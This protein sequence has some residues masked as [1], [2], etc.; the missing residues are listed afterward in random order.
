MK[1]QFMTCRVNGELWEARSFEN[2]LKVDSLRPGQTKVELRGRAANGS[3]VGLT[4]FS[5]EV[6]TYEFKYGEKQECIVN[7]TTQTQTTPNTDMPVEARVVITASDPNA[8]RLS[9][10]F[11]LKTRTPQTVVSNTLTEGRFTDLSYQRK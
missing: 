3:I 8:R 2:A 11:E 1:P 5:L 6:G 4:L 7:Y 9:G 10:T